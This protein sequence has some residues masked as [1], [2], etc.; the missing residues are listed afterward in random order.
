M[1][2]NIASLPMNIQEAIAKAL[3]DAALDARIAAAMDDDTRGPSQTS[4][5][6]RPRVAAVPPIG[7]VPGY[8]GCKCG[9]EVKPGRVWL[10]GHDARNGGHKARMAAQKVAM[11]V[12]AAQAEASRE[13]EKA[14]R[15]AA[16]KVV[17]QVETPTDRAIARRA[18]RRNRK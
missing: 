9:G 2:I 13:R 15:E 14:A 8:C 16:A 4:A 12:L 3:A 5:P 17:E 18:G 7:W 11:D 6:S 10:P 1:N